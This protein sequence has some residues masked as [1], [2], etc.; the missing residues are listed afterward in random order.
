[1][2]F[3]WNW[4][5]S[6]YNFI[7]S[8][9]LWLR[10]RGRAL[11]VT[12]QVRNTMY[13]IFQSDIKKDDIGIDWACASSTVTFMRISK[14]VT[15][16]PFWHLRKAG[17]VFSCLLLRIVMLQQMII[18]VDCYI[19]LIIILSTINAQDKGRQARRGG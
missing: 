4:T 12:G 19:D 7:F 6:S 16:Y 3:T 14:I 9:L 13:N 1:L 5:Y 11:M 8:E 10:S 15:R 18:W 2:P 17:M